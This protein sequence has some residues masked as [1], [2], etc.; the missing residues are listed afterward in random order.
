MPVSKQLLREAQKLI[1]EIK[2][3]QD[4]GSQI[5][6]EWAEFASRCI[7]RS[8]A[9]MVHFN[10]YPYQKFL[11]DAI[12]DFE[13]VELVKTRQMGVTQ[14][15]VSV[16]Q[17]QAALNPAYSGVVFSLTQKDAT[18]VSLRCR[19]MTESLGIK[20]TNDNVGFLQLTGGGSIHFL[21]SSDKGTRGLDSIS[22]LFFDEAA[23]QE[24]PAPIFESSLPSM[25]MVENPCVIVCSTPDSN[26]GW[27]YDRLQFYPLPMPLEDLCEK[28]AT[29]E[30]YTQEPGLYH[31]IDGTKILIILHWRAHPVHRLTDLNYNG[32][33]L[34]KI[35]DLNPD[36][37]WE[38]IY[39]EHNLLFTEVGKS[40]Y[41][42]KAVRNALAPMPNDTPMKFYIGVDPNFG[43]PDYCCA[44][45]LG[46]YMNGLLFIV[47]WYRKQYQTAKQNIEKVKQ[48]I[49]KYTPEVTAVETIA[50]GAVYHEEIQ[51]EIAVLPIL[52]F[53]TN[54]QLKI[55]GAERLGV[56]LEQNQ[57]KFTEDCPIFPELLSMQLD[58]KKLEAPAGKHDDMVMACIFAI[59]AYNHKRQE[60]DYSRFQTY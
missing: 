53:R 15:V 2:L 42:A 18:Q 38:K 21:N 13:V 22:H 48:L 31:F 16:M 41:S 25:A 59:H 44:V 4:P 46:E 58:G 5:P 29:G 26:S 37:S 7:I 43:G 27:Y 12:R 40:F 52:E 33:Y 3:I 57:L 14:G 17:H 56:M 35:K 55:E 32:G 11:S 60:L 36:L 51:R 20:P 6:E 10:P 1:E 47:D 54:N 45:V 30:I 23:F 39:R 28:V 34:Q 19:T 49:N 50:G 24:D 8:G 9:K